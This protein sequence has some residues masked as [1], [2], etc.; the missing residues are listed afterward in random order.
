MRVRAGPASHH[1]PFRR[2]WWRQSLF[3][4][5]VAVIRF[6]VLVHVVSA[7]VTVRGSPAGN[8]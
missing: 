4:N 6:A 1:Q 8:Y 7:A 5:L 3:F 2:L